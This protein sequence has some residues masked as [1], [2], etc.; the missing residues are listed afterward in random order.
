M[1]TENAA[2]KLAVLDPETGKITEY[3][4]PKGAGTHTLREDS[5]GNI[6]TSNKITKF[7]PHSQQFT[8]F[9]V[10]GSSYDV[11]IDSHDNAWGCSGDPK[12]PGLY[13]IDGKTGEIKIYPVAEMRSV[14]GIESDTHDNIW[15]GDVTNHRL[16]KFDT[17][18]EKFTYYEAPTSNMGIYGLVVDR[19]NGN[20]WVGDYEGANVD[21]FDPNT[22]KFVEY[23]FPSR[24]Q[25]IRFFGEDPLG[26]IWFTDF[27]NGRIGVLETED[28][29]LSAK[30]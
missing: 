13:R 12:N 23:P 30:K 16:G 29:K 20:I 11:N 15:F 4:P 10:P 27:T 14:R 19:K 8:V 7:D 18:T 25:M 5:K 6:W 22:G 28:M 1:V 21:R 26:R 2:R 3:T 24:T 9:E 17:K